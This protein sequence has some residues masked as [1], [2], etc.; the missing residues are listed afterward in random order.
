MGNTGAANKN[1]RA[2]KPRRNSINN[3]NGCLS[4]CKESP[5]CTNTR[6]PGFH[7]HIRLNSGVF[8]GGGLSGIFPLRLFQT[9]VE[10]SRVV[11][12]VPPLEEP[13]A[14]CLAHLAGSALL[15]EGLPAE[16]WKR[17]ALPP[18]RA[19]VPADRLLRQVTAFRSSSAECV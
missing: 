8:V 1:E 16:T 19:I 2:A 11:G 7:G 6:H 18:M 14:G 5:A 9:H 17:A 12:D 15:W 13:T 10:P 3:R 4:K